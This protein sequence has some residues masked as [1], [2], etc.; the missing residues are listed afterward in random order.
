MGRRLIGALAATALLL[1]ACSDDDG[2]GDDE[3]ATLESKL[4]TN[5]DLPEVYST[6]PGAGSGQGCGLGDSADAAD[7]LETASTSLLAADDGASL[8]EDISRYEPGAAAAL[9]DRVRESPDACAEDAGAGS[10][11]L[12]AAPLEL[13]DLLDESVGVAVTGE[14]DGQTLTLHQV[15]LREGDVLIV[16]VHGGLVPVDPADTAELARLAADKLTGAADA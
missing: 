8:Y 9:V 6:G 14:V 3:D 11:A 1:S 7:R 15:F 10:V 5:L 13:P 2:G 4:L 16:L 12:T